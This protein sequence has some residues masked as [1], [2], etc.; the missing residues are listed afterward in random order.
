MSTQIGNE[1]AQSA[2]AWMTQRAA[3]RTLFVYTS[4]CS[5]R[6]SIVAAAEV[7]VGLTENLLSSNS[8]SLRSSLSASSLS[9]AALQAPVSLIWFR[10]VGV[11]RSHMTGA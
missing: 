4:D 7:V 9:I 6:L 2:S 5:C 11:C 3:L 8:S 1:C 10:T